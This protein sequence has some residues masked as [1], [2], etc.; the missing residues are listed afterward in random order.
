MSIKFHYFFWGTINCE[1]NE[2]DADVNDVHNDTDDN[3]VDAE[4]KQAVRPSASI[5]VSN[6]H[7]K[8]SR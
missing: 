3:N 6:R 5:D 1:A 8:I 4:P 2:E 7:S